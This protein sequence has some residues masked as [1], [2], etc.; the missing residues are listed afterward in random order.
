[1]SEARG[2][3]ETD[4]ASDG[5]DQESYKYASSSSVDTRSS[6]PTLAGAATIRVEMVNTQV[7]KEKKEYHG[8]AH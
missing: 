1:M 5:E 3:T 2:S 8:A 6:P 4:H 7:K